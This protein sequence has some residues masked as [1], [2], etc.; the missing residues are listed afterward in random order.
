MFP[1]YKYNARAI[2]GAST[3]GSNNENDE[4]SARSESEDLFQICVS[5]LHIVEAF[6]VQNTDIATNGG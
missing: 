4:E 3:Y 6:E 5:P 1:E 2:F